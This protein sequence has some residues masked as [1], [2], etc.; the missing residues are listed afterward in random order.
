MLL[1]KKIKSIRRIPNPLP[2]YNLEIKD[3]HNFFVNGVLTHNCDDPTNVAEAE[4]ELIAESTLE[5]YDNVLS[6]RLNDPKKDCKVIVMQRVSARDLTEHVLKQRGFEHLCLPAE[7]E[8]SRKC[9]TCLWEDPRTIEGEL[10]WPERVGIKEINEYKLR[11]GPSGYSAQF[12]QN[13]AGKDGNRFKQSYF[14]Y[15]KDLG[16]QYKLI[17]GDKIKVIN[18]NDCW[19]FACLDPAGAEKKVN[20]KVCYSVLQVYAVTPDADMLLLAQSRTQDQ[21]PDTVDK[22]VEMC[23]R[24]EVQFLA[25]EKNGLGLGLVQTIQRK[26]IGVI[27]VNA[28]SNKEARSET[29]EVRMAAGMV[30][31]EQGNLINFDLEKELLLFPNGEF[32]DQVDTLSWACILVQQ[33]HGAPVTQEDIIYG[34]V[35]TVCDSTP[36]TGMFNRQ[37]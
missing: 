12:Q 34:E 11:L 16:P 7:Y 2:T 27:P 14:R 26:G 3:N 24:Y 32:A 35:E 20:T 18:K 30:Y 19:I 22:A 25:V 5:W 13:P 10:L 4:S 9:V 6:T 1:K 29:A 33:R 8:S 36:T 15:Y 21:I 17:T 28:T 23:R 37:F 31:F